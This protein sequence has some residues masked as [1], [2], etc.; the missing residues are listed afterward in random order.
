MGM[1]PTSA[2]FLLGVGEGTRWPS[3][4]RAPGNLVLRSFPPQLL[5]FSVGLVLLVVSKP[6][7]SLFLFLFLSLRA[8]PPP[9]VE[10]KVIKDLPWPPPVGQL[11]SGESP[12]DSEAGASVPL[13]HGQP[14]YE[15]ANGGSCM[16]AGCPGVTAASACRDPASLPHQ[17]RDAATPRSLPGPGR[18]LPTDC[19]CCQTSTLLLC[20]PPAPPGLFRCPVPDARRLSSP[21]LHLL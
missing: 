18:A 2:L 7:L 4:L 21:L 11:D 1:C 5:S 12:P 19:R 10:I 6:F 15:D 13:Q 20:L 16:T 17:H 8:P 9:P 14:S 3:W